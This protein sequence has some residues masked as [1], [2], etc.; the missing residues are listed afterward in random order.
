MNERSPNRRT[1]S[2]SAADIWIH[3]VVSSA[4]N[5]TLS[6]YFELVVL[7][8][9]WGGGHRVGRATAD[10]SDRGRGPFVT[11]GCLCIADGRTGGARGTDGQPGR[12][13]DV[14]LIGGTTARR[15]FAP[16]GHYLETW[17]KGDGQRRAP[18]G[19]TRRPENPH[20]SGVRTGGRPD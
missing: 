3:A 12:A 7:H 2:F 18:V 13:A 10:G 16:S 14:A 5:P 19:G 17:A 1:S 9:L 8:C 15:V 20:R 4:E 6:S 11:P